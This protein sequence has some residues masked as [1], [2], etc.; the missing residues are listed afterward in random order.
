MNFI[1]PLIA[2]LIWSINSIVS[3]L[4]ASS[5]DPAAISFYRWLI[6]FLVISPFVIP[7]VIRQRKMIIKYLPKFFV[8]G[9]LGMCIFQ[10]LAYYAAQTIS[11]A[12]MG[13][14]NG[15]IPLLTL[16]LSIFILRTTMTI[17][18]I[19]GGILS[20]VGLVYL[21]TNGHPLALLSNGINKG[22]LLIL[23]ASLAYAFY[24]VLLKKWA[25]AVTPWVSL[26][27][28]IFFGLLCILPLFMSVDNVSLT[29]ENIPLVLF[30]GI[31]ASIIAPFTWMA[32][33]RL[34]GAYKAS[35]FLNFAPIFTLI[36]AAIFLNESI[37]IH[38]VIG[39]ALVLIGVFVA[40][41]L[42]KVPSYKSKNSPRKLDK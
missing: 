35:I 19:V 20:F 29:A 22:E 6:A 25:I 21:V 23:L 34:L 3:K 1:Y 9:A 36:I 26:Y 5:I 28:Q 4:A 18:L 30:A 27:M 32:G 7:S 42:K 10:G 40:Q 2:V 41:T 15:V 11:A 37:T 17:G 16:I 14:A 24:G 38:F 12:L 39:T 33:I 8:L 31:P 13:V